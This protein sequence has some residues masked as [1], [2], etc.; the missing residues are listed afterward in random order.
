MFKNFTV[1]GVNPYI[2][3]GVAAIMLIIAWKFA[4]EG[5]KGD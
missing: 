2:A 5:L 1:S 4:V 3:V